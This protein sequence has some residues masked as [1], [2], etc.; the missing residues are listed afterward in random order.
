[1]SAAEEEVN[2]GI[3]PAEER[4]PATLRRAAIITAS[5]AI[6]HGVLLIVAFYLLKT[7]APFGGASDEQIRNF[8]AD[9]NNRRLVLVAGIYLVPFS[10]IAFVWFIVALRMWEANSVKRMNQLFANIQLVTG[11]IYVTLLLCAG[12]ALSVV[13]TG[14]EFTDAALDPAYARQFPQFGA[15]LFLTLSMRMAATFV[16]ATSNLLR[17]E[18]ILPRWF[19]TIGIVVGLLLLLSASISSWLVIVFP[20]WLVVLGLI[21]LDRARK[22]E[23]EPLTAAG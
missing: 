13:A 17:R 11:I 19:L 14:L 2:L 10:A 8:Y 6:A 1:M 16:F 4:D 22:L 21:L 9:P 23:G 18:G 20:T 5:C 12:A 7:R 15:T 3:R